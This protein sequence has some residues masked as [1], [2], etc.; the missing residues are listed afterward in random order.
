GMR[1]EALLELT[2]GVKTADKIA[3]AANIL[4]RLKVT[5]QQTGGESID[6]AAIEIILKL[7]KAGGKAPLSSLAAGNIYQTMAVLKEMEKSNLV[8]IYATPFRTYVALTER[9]LKTLKELVS[10]LT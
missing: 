9:G 1:N 10:V 2:K 8:K 5:S 6:S 4:Y 3:A 7:A